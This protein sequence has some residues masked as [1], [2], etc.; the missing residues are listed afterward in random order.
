MEPAHDVQKVFLQNN[1]SK[2]K[3]S[4]FFGRKLHH[5]WDRNLLNLLVPQ[6]RFEANK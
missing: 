3:Q 2:E 6:E 5:D 4:P 1:Q